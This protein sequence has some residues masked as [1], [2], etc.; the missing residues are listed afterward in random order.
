MR[1]VLALLTLV[2]LLSS[3]PLRVATAANMSEAIKTLITHYKTAHPDVEIKINIA[4]SSKLATQILHQAP[5]DIFLCANTQYANKL[6]NAGASTKPL[7]YARGA[8]VLLSRSLSDLSNP[9][10]LLLSQKVKKIAIANPKTAP[11]GKAAQEYLESQGIYKQVRSKLVFGESV[12]QTLS[13]TLRATD[14][15]IVAKSALFTPYI[16]NKQ[17]QLHWVELPQNSYTP[18]EQAMVRIS[19]TSE[20][21]EFYSYLQSDEAKTILRQYGYTTP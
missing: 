8:L 12:A 17:E 4:S 15:G 14:V 19:N 5:Y 11:Y 13:Y 2:T 21:K 16:Q 20:A 7:I 1:I 18:I 6:Y 10:S 9:K 3:Q